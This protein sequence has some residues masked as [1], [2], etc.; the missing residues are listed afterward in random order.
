MRPRRS[1]GWFTQGL[2]AG[3]LVAALAGESAAAEPKGTLVDESLAWRVYHYAR[4]LPQGGREVWYEVRR[5]VYTDRKTAFGSMVVD[6]EPV[7]IGEPLARP[8]RRLRGAG[9]GGLENRTA[10]VIV[11]DLRKDERGFVQRS[12]RVIALEAGDQGRITQRTI[13]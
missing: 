13:R 8:T 11:E 5:L 12:I 4:A 7:D 10:Y 1:F 6:E 3:M 9:L 2:V